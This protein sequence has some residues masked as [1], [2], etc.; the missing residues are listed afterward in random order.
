MVEI[1]L[2]RERIKR[3]SIIFDAAHTKARYN[4]KLSKDFPMG[5]SKLPYS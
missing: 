2:E 3:K 1:V 5:K 4:Q